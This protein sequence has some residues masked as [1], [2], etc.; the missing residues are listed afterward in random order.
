MLMADADMPSTALYLVVSSYICPHLVAWLDWPLV[1]FQ[2]A[3][4][5]L[6]F[7]LLEVC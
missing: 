5:L 1:H 7:L 6:L 4:E 2:I 3:D